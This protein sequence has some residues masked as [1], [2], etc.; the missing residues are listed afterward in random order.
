MCGLQRIDTGDGTVESTHYQPEPREL[1]THVHIHPLLADQPRPEARHNGAQGQQQSPCDQH[2]PGVHLKHGY[3]LL[4]VKSSS[5]CAVADRSAVAGTA[6]ATTHLIGRTAVELHLLGEQVAT[7]RWSVVHEDDNAP[8]R[9]VQGIL[10]RRQAWAGLGALGA[11]VKLGFGWQWLH[12]SSSVASP[13]CVVVLRLDESYTQSSFKLVPGFSRKGV[14]KY[15]ASC[16][17]KS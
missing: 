2:Q 4:I 6:R 10:I 3:T 15:L 1:H 7:R 14:G 13:P 9:Y 8:E 5:G 17:S 11:S 16:K 12:I